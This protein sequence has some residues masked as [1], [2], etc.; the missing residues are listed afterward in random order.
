MR[1]YIRK[2]FQ[3]SLVTIFL[4][5]FPGSA[6]WAVPV[7]DQSVDATVA[8]GTRKIS[9]FIYGPISGRDPLERA[10]IFTVGASGVLTDIEVMVGRLNRVSDPLMWELRDVS[11]GQPGANVLANGSTAA[12]SFPGLGYGTFPSA[13]PGSFISLGGLSLIVDVGDVFAI[14]LRTMESTFAAYSWRSTD[15][16]YAGGSQ[17]TWRNSSDSW[18]PATSQGDP[19][20]A[21]FRTFVDPVVEMLEPTTLAL[22]SLGLAGIGFS[23]KKK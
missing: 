5:T 4:I 8:T 6:S 22:M 18:L 20:Y 16:P 15:I 23:R 9:G 21:G 11:A 1:S 19:I 7:L 3:A 17:L 14:V 10:Q 12:A 13:F 2:I